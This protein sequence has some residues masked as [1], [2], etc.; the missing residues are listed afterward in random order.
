[1]KKIKTNFLKISVALLALICLALPFCFAGNQTANAEAS[2]LSINLSGIG[3]STNPY[4]IGTALQMKTFANY[5]IGGN[6]T[7][8]MYFELTNDINLSSYSPWTPIGYDST[9]SSKWFS[10]NFNG[11]GHTISNINIS[12]TNQYLGLFG[13]IGSSATLTNFE[14]QNVNITGSGLTSTCYAGSVLGYCAS[15]TV[16]ISKVYVSSGTI[17]VS[18]SG[19]IALVLGGIVGASENASLNIQQCWANVEI[20]SQST[21][22][23]KG[24]ILGGSKGTIKDCYS[25]QDLTLVSDNCSVG[26]NYLIVEYSYYYFYENDV[27]KFKYYLDQNSNYI[28]YTDVFASTVYNYFKTKSTNWFLSGD[29]L[30]L[31]NVGNV[32]VLTEANITVV[33]RYYDVATKS[34]QQISSTD[35]KTLN[36]NSTISQTFGTNTNANYSVN[37]LSKFTTAYFNFVKDASDIAITTTSFSCTKPYL[38]YAEEGYTLYINYT[39]GILINIDSEEYWLCKSDDKIY[40]LTQTTSTELTTSNLPSQENK[41]FL[42]FSTENTSVVGEWNGTGWYKNVDLLVEAVRDGLGQTPIDYAISPID[43]TPLTTQDFSSY[44][45]SNPFAIF[46]VWG[47][48]N[49]RANI[50]VYKLVNGSYTK[51]YNYHISCATAT[52]TTDYISVEKNQT[53]TFSIKNALNITL[54]TSKVGYQIAWFIGTIENNDINQLSGSEYGSLS[55]T[56]LA[57]TEF[58][59]GTAE[60]N[61][62]VVLTPRTDIGIEILLTD[63]EGKENIAI[64]LNNEDFDLQTLTYGEVYTIKIENIPNGYYLKGATAQSGLTTTFDINSQTA[65]VTFTVD[66]NQDITITLNIQESIFNNIYFYLF[67]AIAIATITVALYLIFTNKLAKKTTNKKV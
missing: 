11:N 21:N 1:M 19:N 46:S 41:Y 13:Y 8:G 64:K 36:L 42:G 4:K 30:L 67:I 25:I 53:Y 9:N 24:S 50:A 23:R 48:D 37:Y 40:K 52:T 12:A 49:I 2:T 16:E 15:G 17:N 65:T 56:N 34:W 6:S 58:T 63:F 33:E 47:N 32:F 51:I 18:S 61:I 20:E 10:G 43:F 22:V 66:F 60:T 28:C 35:N 62:L 27:Q 5:V 39:N 14:I 38:E 44:S 26:L 3:S 31:R 57:T 45:V 59:N 29:E 7:S 54:D 55:T